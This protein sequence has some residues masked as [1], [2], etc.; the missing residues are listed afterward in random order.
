MSRLECFYLTMIVSVF[1][2]LVILFSYYHFYERP[3]RHVEVWYATTDT[4]T[5][6]NV[7]LQDSLRKKIRKIGFD[8]KVRGME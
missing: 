7:K 6:E 8:V 5:T 4:V 3:L 1:T 2:S